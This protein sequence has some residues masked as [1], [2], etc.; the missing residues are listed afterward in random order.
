MGES[1]LLVY[2]GVVKIPNNFK[3]Q[4]KQ[5]QKK[6]RKNGNFYAKSVFNNNDYG[7]WCKFKIY[8]H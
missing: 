7:F 1:I 8:Y 6:I 2:S 4:G 3:A 5:K